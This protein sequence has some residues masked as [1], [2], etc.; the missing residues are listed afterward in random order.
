MSTNAHIPNIP[1]FAA[2]LDD[3]T[4]S[5][6]YACHE[7]CKLRKGGK[8]TDKEYNQRNKNVTLAHIRHC[9]KETKAHNSVYSDIVTMGDLARK[10]PE[11]KWETRLAI[12][13]LGEDFCATHYSDR[14]N[15]IKVFKLAN[16]LMGT[17]E[18]PETEN[19]DKTEVTIEKTEE[20]VPV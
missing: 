6:L 11:C 13:A 7:A 19:D 3:D 8:F 4:L 14:G 16:G 5:M 1:N 17:D 10:S 18:K 12:Y 2:H 20:A 15:A 9:I